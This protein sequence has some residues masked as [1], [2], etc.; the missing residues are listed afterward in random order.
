[1]KAQDYLDSMVIDDRAV[2][3]DS[4]VVAKDEIAKIKD[5]SSYKDTVKRGFLNPEEEQGLSLPW[6][7]ATEFK[8]RDSEL[9]IWTGYNG[10]KKSMM[11]G[12]VIL[13]LI[14]QGARG[15]IASLEM[16]PRKTLSRMCK[17]WIGVGD[18]G[19]QYVEKYFSWLHKKLWIYDQVGTVNMTRML[20]VARYAI[21]ELGVTHFVIDSL[22]KCGIAE[23]DHTKQKMFV[24]ELSTLAKD[25]GAHI[26]LVAHAKKPETGKES[27]PSTKYGVSGSGHL[28]NM[29]DNVIISF[30]QKDDTKDYDQMLIVDKQ[31]NG[32]A[33][34][35]YILNF[36]KESLQFKG[37]SN[38]PRMN[39]EDWENGQWR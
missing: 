9:T 13:G 15:C 33:E 37:F 5:A 10:H 8:F 36:D 22:M 29:A 14:S 31:R 27:I 16:P 1:M 25:T 34:P 38:S 2:N 3:F 23:D 35:K 7:K 32:E 39:H 28:T 19:M 24:D 21:T 12:F 30:S 20:G 26:H 18:P 6:A 17:Q 11:L 4:Y